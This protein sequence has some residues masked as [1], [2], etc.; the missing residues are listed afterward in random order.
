MDE[1]GVE[2]EDEEA[3]EPVEPWSRRENGGS[4][5][6]SDCWCPLRL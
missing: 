4:R 1:S 3:E 2:F 5:P 6:A